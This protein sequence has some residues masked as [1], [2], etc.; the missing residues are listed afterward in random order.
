M[1]DVKWYS[2]LKALLVFRTDVNDYSKFKDLFNVVIKLKAFNRDP[3]N[4]W[5]S[6][7]CFQYK[8]GVRE[9]NTMYVYSALHRL[10]FNVGNHY[11]LDVLRG[12]IR[13]GSIVVE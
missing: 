13:R 1:F 5:L 4:A 12:A 11:D 3:R 7:I 8:V 9:F 2:L 10:Y 6:T